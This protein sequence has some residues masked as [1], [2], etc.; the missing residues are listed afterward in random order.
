[1]FFR[2]T[3][4]ENSTSIRISSLAAV[5]PLICYCIALVMPYHLPQAEESSIECDDGGII[6]VGNASTSSSY[7]GFL[8]AMVAP[9]RGNTVLPERPSSPF[10]LPRTMSLVRRAATADLNGQ[11]YFQVGTGCTLQ[12]KRRALIDVIDEVLELVDPFEDAASCE[13]HHQSSSPKHNGQ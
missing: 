11:N 8:A 9:Q 3:K 4:F 12:E 7:E 2:F 6:E 10:A 13:L 5:E 1:M